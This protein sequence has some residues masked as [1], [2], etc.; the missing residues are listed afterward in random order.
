MSIPA[1]ERQR[2]NALVTA[3]AQQ[4]KSIEAKRLLKK[5]EDEKLALQHARE[6][7]LRKLAAQLEEERQ[8][9]IDNL[10]QHIANAFGKEALS[11][12]FNSSLRK[13][14]GFV[15]YWKYMV[16]R[17]QNENRVKILQR[18]REELTGLPQSVLDKLTELMN[19]KKGITR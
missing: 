5:K 11:E 13:E 7:A 18:I 1:V 12:L 14:S 6:E 9:N 16:C 19:Q 2:L 3:L 15:Q 17:E 8:R 4:V 10:A